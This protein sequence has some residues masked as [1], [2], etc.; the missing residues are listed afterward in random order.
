M[1]QKKLLIIPAILLTVQTAH[2][3]APFILSAKDAQLKKRQANVLCVPFVKSNL[4]L[5]GQ[6]SERFW[7]KAAVV[8]DWKDYPSGES[9][10]HRAELRIATDSKN[11]LVGFTRFM[12][13][14]TKDEFQKPR[15]GG[16]EYGASILEMFFDPSG[17]GKE[18]F[19]CCANPTGLR[20]DGHNNDKKWN[21][22]WKSVGI[23][24]DD[25]WTLEAILPLSDFG[26]ESLPPNTRWEGNFGFVLTGDIHNSWS[27]K[28]GSP[29]SDYGDLFFGT[30]KEY[31]KTVKPSIK[32]WLDREVY[33]ARDVTAVALARLS[34]MGV[35]SKG[36]EL[37]VKLKGTQNQ[38]VLVEKIPVVS[39]DM[40]LTL[41]TMRLAE[42]SYSLEV[43]ILRDGTAVASA[44]RAFKKEK[45]SFIPEGPKSGRI[46][47]SLKPDRNA[48]A[49]AWPVSPGVAFAQG[50]L[51]S[52]DNV[53]LLGP[54]GKEVACQA[55]A[56][57]RWN[58]NGSIQ[59]LGLEFVPKAQASEQKFTLEYGPDIKRTTQ[60]PLICT[61]TSKAVTVNTGPLRIE[62]GRKPF[63]LLNSVFLDQNK[64]GL[65][66]PEE[67]VADAAE[68]GGA[69]LV[70]HEGA[71]YEAAADRNAEVVVEESGPVRATILC[72]GW[73]VKKGSAG[74]HTSVELPTD[75]LCQ[76]TFRLSAFAGQTLLK[77]SATTVLTY[78]STK[79]RLKDLSLTLRPTST[80]KITLGSG[81][82]SFQ[83]NEER[84]KTN[85]HL[86]AHRWDQSIE[87]DWNQRGRA[88]GWIEA[89]STKAKMRLAVR[90][91]WKLFPKE[92]EWKDGA[93]N[94]HIWPAHG[95]QT[96]GRYDELKWENIYKLWY[97]H[98]GHELDFQLPAEYK[99]TLG[100]ELERTPGAFGDYYT[101]M[102]FSNAQG[103]AI[104]N[105][106]V[107]DFSA[108]DD[109]AAPS[110]QVL[111]HLADTDPVPAADP[112]YTC[113]TGVFGPMLHADMQTF[114][115]LEK[116]LELGYRSLS[117]RTQ[118]NSE[119]GMFIY[120][121][122]HTYWY[123]HKQPAHAGVHRVW[124]NGHYSIGRMPIVQFARTGDPYYLQ[125]G[126]DFSANLRDTAMVHYVSEE[127]RFR[128]HNLG[129]MYH[130]KG[131]APWA[132]D[133][134]VAAHP[135]STDWLIYYYYITGDR[136]SRD[137]F[138]TWIE[139]LKIAS[140]G[141]FGTRE[142]IQTLGEMIEAYRYSWD[143][144]LVELMDRFAQP[145][146]YGIPIKE[147]HWFDY[148]SLLPI[149]YHMLTGNQ[150]VLDVYRTAMEQGG[151]GTGG[152]SFHLEAL[153][154]QL[155]GKKEL[156]NDFPFLLH[157][158][159]VSCVQQKGMLHDGL[160]NN[161][162]LGYI[163]N[164]HK[165]P[166][167]LKA[168]KEAG[169][170]SQRPDDT[171]P[172]FVPKQQ[173]KS[174]LAIRETADQEVP[175]TLT[176]NQTPAGKVLITVHRSDKPNVFQKEITLE[177]GITEATLSIPADGKADDYLI[178][179]TLPGTYD[180]VQFPVSPLP[181]EVA[182]CHEGRSE[183]SPGKFGTRYFT[184]SGDSAPTRFNFSSDSKQASGMELLDKNGTRLA[185]VSDSRYVGNPMTLNI[186]AA[187]PGPLSFYLSSQAYLDLQEPQKMLIL[188]ARPEALFQPK[189][190]QGP[191]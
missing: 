68:N 104:H 8:K 114:P 87:D 142:G 126:R 25:K 49:A 144:A 52:T 106:L 57:S 17:A 132:G 77:L 2:A 143:P 165:M 188:S 80:Q 98:Q 190:T 10:L 111:S 121:G 93:L 167:L 3:E 175:L 185:L 109:S 30:E 11:I 133:S 31:A 71:I 1:C 59:W 163:Y 7:K 63:S 75:R 176:F 39:L 161:M 58:R 28:W 55:A 33:D 181:L 18:K 160:T 97:C 105:D 156:L 19:Q 187:T 170:K 169:L 179:I 152:G 26:V 15:K 182:I 95:R 41:N 137:V 124:I 186:P 64:N 44:N 103:L 139:G 119:Y 6:L 151:G 129:A 94:L 159:C 88:D 158:Q 35:A 173:G 110:G 127:R 130:C 23:I 118:P 115:E 146:F 164:F 112:A 96:F 22:Q 91:F 76:F 155:E 101:A 149:R 153:F 36:L 120:G 157:K 168:M 178:E 4:K 108:S 117:E 24:K 148:H 29:G 53:R 40:D 150:R 79:V 189:I 113:A 84:L 34:N 100:K 37:Q 47:L 32:L 122:A 81:G 46:A 125:W 69:Y 9:S 43:S 13:G 162:W 166:Y 72:K 62:I 102:E 38:E 78:D 56:R 65:F 70:D 136:R 50:V 20:Y 89:E 128:Y 172:T 85:P 116:S 141:G 45:R 147:H 191:K 27:G 48:A 134:A 171:I 92:I 123:Y 60:S 174:L 180:F 83:W 73:Y 140:P 135:A 51:D 61:E 107:F 54:D 5:D 90:N 67:K 16:D 183:I 42:G 66:E 154:S 131:F 14:P 177:K 99:Q 138:E 82:S 86:L 184:L 21:G 74:K 145:I 12:D